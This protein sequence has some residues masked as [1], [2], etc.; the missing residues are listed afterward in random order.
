LRYA[1]IARYALAIVAAAA[2]GSA[3]AAAPEDAQPSPPP[4]LRIVP[5]QG[6]GPFALRAGLDGL[7]R[8][9]GSEGMERTV[10]DMA[11]AT[12]ECDRRT[13]GRVIRLD[14][15]QHGLWLTADERSRALRVLSAYGTLQHF[16]TDRGVRLGSVADAVPRLYGAGFERIS[17]R[18]PRA[19]GTAVILRYNDLGIQF[20]AAYG[21]TLANGR[22]FE[23][24]VFL[25]GTFSSR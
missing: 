9:I 16:V 12:R 18:V 23:I 22:L 14:W 25:P 8:A 20:T 6:I 21:P 15:R 2:V 13:T 1:P 19:N 10:V 24:G 5:G 4:V 3:A 17:C 11:E 7:V